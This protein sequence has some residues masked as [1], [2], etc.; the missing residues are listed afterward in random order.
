MLKTDIQQI[1]TSFENQNAIHVINIYVHELAYLFVMT[2]MNS[3]IRK[4]QV[5]RVSFFS[6][7]LSHYPFW[8]TV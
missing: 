3:R 7:F 6:S 5:Y 1:T 4:L 2:I 8:H